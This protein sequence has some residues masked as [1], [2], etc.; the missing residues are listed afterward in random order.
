MSDKRVP[1]VGD[2]VVV[3][4]RGDM[5]SGDTYRNAT[6]TKVGRKYCSVSGHQTRFSLMDMRSDGNYGAPDLVLYPDEAAQHRVDEEAS[7]FLRQLGIEIS[8]FSR[9]PGRLWMLREQTDRI[10]H[11]EIRAFKN[12]VL[13]STVH[14]RTVQ[15]WVRLLQASDDEAKVEKALRERVKIEREK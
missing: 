11:A 1:V 14:G 8:C 12:R 13:A 15:E 3:L 6:V 7:Q 2:A 9:R 5:S 4:R 10:V